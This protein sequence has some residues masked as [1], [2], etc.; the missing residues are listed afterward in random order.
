MNEIVELIEQ[1]IE[2]IGN[3]SY[4]SQEDEL[5]DMKELDVFEEML[6]IVEEV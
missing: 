1:K 3:N 2:E 4:T 6:R 5:Q